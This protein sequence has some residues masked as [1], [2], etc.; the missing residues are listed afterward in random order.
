MEREL[1]S[2]GGGGGTFEKISFNDREANSQLGVIMAFLIGVN[3]L[4]EYFIHDLEMVLKHR[5]Q[6]LLKMMNAIYKEL[7]VLGFLQLLIFT[8][9]ET[10]FFKNMTHTDFPNNLFEFAHYWLFITMLIF[11]I[12]IA[13]LAILTSKLTT[14][15]KYSELMPRHAV[16]QLPLKSIP[17]IYHQFRVRFI[18]RNELPA[19]FDFSM[20]LRKCVR[21][22]SVN[23]IEIHW[24]VWFV[25][26]IVFSLNIGR[27]YIIKN[28]NDAINMMIAYGILVNTMLIIYLKCRW[29]RKQLAEN[30]DVLLDYGNVEYGKEYWQVQLDNPDNENDDSAHH[31]THEGSHERLFCFCCRCKDRNDDKEELDF[32]EHMQ[33]SNESPDQP[34]FQV[35]VRNE[36]NKNVSL[37]QLTLLQLMKKKFAMKWLWWI[38]GSR[39]AHERLFWFSSKAFLRRL[40]QLCIIVNCGMLGIYFVY[41]LGKL[42]GYD[43]AAFVHI[44][45]WGGFIVCNVL[46]YKMY[47]IL[48][49]I[50]Y[51]GSLTSK[52]IVKKTLFKLKHIKET[53]KERNNRAAFKADS[54][55]NK[56][57]KSK[58]GQPS[59]PNYFV[60]EKPTRTADDDDGI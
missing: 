7:M 34:N 10:S 33:I 49:L 13:M 20:Y 60:E 46:F 2:G 32:L 1:L 28:A 22:L 23:M 36:H 53:I 24:L 5:A 37:S 15:W 21:E 4:V 19:Y 43:Y 16:K 38:G 54:I 26:F 25:I 57:T 6:H 55:K 35:I 41:F 31:D 11:I 48:V 12:T 42:P 51:T 50:S 45:I 3:V 8:E 27:L 29:I 52:R 59:D 56:S 9:L 47:P 17:Y 40:V 30:E 58:S 39:S 44:Y 18:T 14:D